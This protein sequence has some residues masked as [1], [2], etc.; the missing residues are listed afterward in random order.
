MTVVP[1]YESIRRIMLHV[2]KSYLRNLNR[3]VLAELRKN[4]A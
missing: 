4:V 1:S 3:R 2:D